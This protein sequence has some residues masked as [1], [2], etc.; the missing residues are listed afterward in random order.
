MSA[1]TSASA[2]IGDTKPTGG[3]PGGSATPVRAQV[4]VG[5]LL[6]EFLANVDKVEMHDRFWADDLIYTV[7]RAR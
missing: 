5:N 7:R 6:R 3:R 1:L 4:E 2:Q